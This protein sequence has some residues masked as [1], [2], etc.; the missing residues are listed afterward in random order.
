M[1]DRVVP[2]MH[3]NIKSTVLLFISSVFTLIGEHM[4]K[5]SKKH[6]LDQF[7]IFPFGHRGRRAW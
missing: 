6:H 5:L 4:E 3:H 1:V 2:V 7:Q